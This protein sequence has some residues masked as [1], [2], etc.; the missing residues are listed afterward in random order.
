MRSWGHEITLREQE[1]SDVSLETFYVFDKERPDKFP[2]AYDLP[3]APA[4]AAGF[5]I[6]SKLPDRQA[7]IR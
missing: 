1:V 6:F 2:P 7:R 4:A 3:W 5:L